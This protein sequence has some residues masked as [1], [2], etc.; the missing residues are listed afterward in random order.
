M[1]LP[2]LRPWELA[3]RRHGELAWR[4]QGVPAQ[5]ISVLLR[6]PPGRLCEIREFGLLGSVFRGAKRSL[7][8]QT[9]KPTTI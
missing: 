3:W 6:R 2:N 8:A 7:L 5:L 1:I 4:R 9:P